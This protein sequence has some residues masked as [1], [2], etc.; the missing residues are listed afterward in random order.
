MI[1]KIIH[2]IW[3]GPP[4]PDWVQRNIAEFRRLSPDFEVRIH[5]ED[6]LLPQYAE[7]YS[8]ITDVC[9]KSDVLAV[10]ALQRWGGWYFD[11]D[12][13]PFRPVGSIVEAYA[14][15][16]K[17]MFV[18]EQHGQKNAALRTANGILAA[19]VDW[20]GWPMIENAIAHPKFPIQRCD[21]GP[22][23][24]TRLVDQHPPQF[25]VGSWPFFYPA[26]IGRA[27]RLYPECVK[28]G[29]VVAKR[30]APTGGQL[31]FVMHL[32]TGGSLGVNAGQDARQIAALPGEAGG[33]WAGLRACLA[34]LQI[35]WNDLT[36]PFQAIAHG[37]AHVGIDVDV[38][39]VNEPLPL[40]ATDLVVTW[41]GRKGHYR[42]AADQARKLGLP[43]ICFEHGF[44]ARRQYVQMDHQ[45]ILHW[46]S[47]RD[48]FRKPA[49]AEG[50]ARLAAVWPHELRPFGAGRKGYVLV[51]G[52][53]PGDSQMMESEFDI[54]LPLAKAVSR[55]LPAGVRG[56]FRGHPAMAKP[57]PV[58]YLPDCQAPGI[59]EA[60]EGAR[61][62]VTINSNAG[63]ECLA[64][65]CPVLCL[66]P[67]LYA[68][69]GVALQTTM[70]T[71]KTQ[72]DR[73]IA[74]WMPDGAAVRNYLHWLACRQYSGEEYREGTVLAGILERAGIR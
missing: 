72:F 25:V 60:I 8:H 38:R 61:F 28:R 12:Y 1:P 49:P 21:F 11:C 63:N 68:Q 9:T 41:N 73:M 10:S 24:M 14:L 5:G 57:K 19:T 48:E 42:G 37:L 35:Q 53:L 44:F 13:W 62:A 70:A 7:T 33:R 32:W 36:Q 16:G 47:L 43:V 27:G 45:G 40:E 50:A 46:S 31:P 58:K 18:T 52:Q 34:I 64:L 66:G 54:P 51:I 65:G 67:A 22:V 39:M 55:S 4:M 6:V 17:Q 69:A 74:G 15:D 20:S 29:A 71:F 59:V 2:F 23:L 30:L 26:E 3:F 56:V